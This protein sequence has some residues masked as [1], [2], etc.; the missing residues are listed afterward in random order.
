MVTAVVVGEITTM[1]AT[2][3]VP[4]V[5]VPDADAAVR[6]HDQGHVPPSAENEAAEVNEAVT[7]IV[8]TGENENESVHDHVRG[9]ARHPPHGHDLLH[10]HV[11][12]RQPPPLLSTVIKKKSRQYRAAHQALTRFKT[13]STTAVVFFF[14][15]TILGNLHV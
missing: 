2:V 7:V 5:A 14:K 6:T 12:H 1:K 10:G 8:R 11:L 9:H 15:N 4:V 13:L 3:A